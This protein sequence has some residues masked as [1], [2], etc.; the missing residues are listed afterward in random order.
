[1]T[2]VGQNILITIRLKSVKL[3]YGNIRFHLPTPEICQ[4]RNLCSN[5][6]ITIVSPFCI[7]TYIDKTIMVYARKHSAILPIKG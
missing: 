7:V 2:V 4:A 1:M 3:F 5:P 6:R